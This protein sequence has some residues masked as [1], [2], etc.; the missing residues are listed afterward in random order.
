MKTSDQTKMTDLICK[1]CLKRGHRKE[2]C[3]VLDPKMA[4][5][6]CTYCLKRGHRKE[7]CWVLNPTQLPWKFREGSSR[8]ACIQCGRTHYKGCC[9]VTADTELANPHR[10]MEKEANDQLASVYENVQKRINARKEEVAWLR[11][12]RYMMTQQKDLILE[13][14]MNKQKL[15]ARDGKIPAPG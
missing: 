1:Y 7:T 8:T 14:I 5:L 3:W 6:I 2:T 10:E 11:K 9:T 15:R 13:D 4:D 12:E